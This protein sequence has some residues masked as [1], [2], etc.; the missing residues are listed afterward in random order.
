MKRLTFITYFVLLILIS[1]IIGYA[2][3]E[4]TTAEEMYYLDQIKEEPQNLDPYLGLAKWYTRFGQFDKA[5]NILS[6][7]TSIA[8]NNPA[9]YAAFGDAYGSKQ[10][11]AQA[12]E[13][14]NLAV[15]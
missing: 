1:P 5:V 6:Q 4:P 14:Y 15:K 2:A 3:D 7:A 10:K 9:L 11:L 12:A 8:P 13:M